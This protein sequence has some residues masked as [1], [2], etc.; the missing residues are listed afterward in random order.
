MYRAS[1]ASLVGSLM[2]TMV[3]TRSDL[4]YAVNTVN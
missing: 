1:D 4:M 2:Y 3:C